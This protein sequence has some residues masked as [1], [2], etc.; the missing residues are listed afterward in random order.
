VSTQATIKE[1]VPENLADI[2]RILR[3]TFIAASERTYPAEIMEYSRDYYTVDRLKRRLFGP[4]AIALGAFIDMELMGFAWAALYADGVLSIEW[5]TVR[6]DMIGKGIFS[7][8]ITGLETRGRT[9]AAFKAF[10]YASIKNTPAI[11][12][13]LKLGY[14]VEGVHRN[15]FFGWDFVSMGKIL[16]QK[17]Q[18]GDI[19]MQPDA[20]R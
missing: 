13:Y 11:Q 9:K 7:Q 19:T 2:Q 16:I 5:A 18:L 8:L 4:H 17:P 6:P 1:I 10:L 20:T 3:E 15:H 12:R 14:C